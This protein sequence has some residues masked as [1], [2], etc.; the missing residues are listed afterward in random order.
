MT[1]ICGPLSF[2]DCSDR[3]KKLKAVDF[4]IKEAQFEEDY[5]SFKDEKDFAVF[6]TSLPA[7]C[8]DIGHDIKALLVPCKDASI[9]AEYLA[10]CDNNNRVV[11]LVSL[12]DRKEDY[13]SF[14]SLIE[15]RDKDVLETV[16]YY[17]YYNDSPVLSSRPLFVHRNTIL[18][19]L[20]LF[21]E[22]T[23]RSLLL[24]ADRM[25]VY[26]LI[27]SYLKKEDTLNEEI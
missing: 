14:Y 11:P 19:R 9:Y 22:K 13:V 12:R 27:D 4:L 3:E 25:F 15:N 21:K 17:R 23:G 20:N 1:R 2:S 6:A 26:N 8:E 5:V 16:F 7:L 24:F 10:K 18:Y